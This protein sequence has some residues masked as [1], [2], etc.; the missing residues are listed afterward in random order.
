EADLTTNDPTAWK[1]VVVGGRVASSITIS[2]VLGDPIRTNRTSGISFDS[3]IEYRVETTKIPDNGL[4]RS[5]LLR[6]AERVRRDRALDGW[7]P[8]CALPGT[9]DH[10]VAIL[11]RRVLPSVQDR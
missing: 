3:S 6:S 10:T 11:Y 1:S 2:D 7:S 4:G 5:E 8:V 9:D